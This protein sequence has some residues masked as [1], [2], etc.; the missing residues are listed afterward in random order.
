MKAR[1]WT[2]PA[3]AVLLASAAALAVLPARWLLR[4]LPAAWPVTAV[5]ASGTVWSGQARLAI[6]PPGRRRT[7]PQA[8][9]WQWH[10]V[11]GVGPAAQLVHPWLAAP[12]QIAPGLHGARLGQGRLTMPA[13][14]LATAGAPL[15]TLEPAGQMTLTWP[16]LNLG[17][18]PSKG[19]L[20]RLTWSGASSARVPGR[21]LGDYQAL[22]DADGAGGMDLRV[23]TVRG[24][25]HVEGHGQ[26]R[27]GRWR[28]DGLAHPAD[29]TDPATRAAL[30]PLLGALGAT[31]DGVSRMQYP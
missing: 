27:G 21:P 22:L 5:D 29:D 26:Q 14:A 1:R 16:A 9:S 18:L 31:R 17:N 19:V 10:W 4:V 25:L 8:V 24:P 2:L 6:G 20:L 12:V 15:D 30:A 23:Q 13:S 3:T 7:L 28:Y 11:Q